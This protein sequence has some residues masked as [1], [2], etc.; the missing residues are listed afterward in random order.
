[1]EF[2][3]CN[4]AIYCSLSAILVKIYGISRPSFILSKMLIK[5][6]SEGKLE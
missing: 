6:R 5:I 4:L 3:A 2:L 1:V